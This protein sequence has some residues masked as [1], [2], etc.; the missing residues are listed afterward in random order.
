MPR[1]AER[2]VLDSEDARLDQAREAVSFYLMLEARGHVDTALLYARHEI[3]VELKKI[4]D[5]ETSAEAIAQ[6]LHDSA[7]TTLQSILAKTKALKPQ[8][9]IAVD[10][11]GRVVARAGL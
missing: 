1:P 5:D 9:L 8:M 2:R 6:Q 7:Q 11:W 4:K 3:Y 10:A